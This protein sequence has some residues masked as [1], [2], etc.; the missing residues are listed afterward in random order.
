LPGFAREQ[1][2]N[3]GLSVNGLLQVGFVL[4]SRHFKRIAGSYQNPFYCN[5]S[6]ALWD[7]ILGLKAKKLLGLASIQLILFR[8]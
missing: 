3:A 5:T 8:G 6:L 2:D 7:S 4:D 1:G